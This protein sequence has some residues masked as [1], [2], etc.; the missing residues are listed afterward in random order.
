MFPSVPR[1]VRFARC[2]RRHRLR[3]AQALRPR[4]ARLRHDAAARPRL[5]HRLALTARPGSRLPPGDRSA[6]GHPSAARPILRRKFRS[7]TRRRSRCDRS[8]RPAT[9]LV[10]AHFHIWRMAD[11]P[12]LMGPMQPRIFGPCEPIRR[13][14]SIAEY[15]DDI[16]GKVVSAAIYVQA[17]W[18]RERAEDEVAWV[19]SVAEETGWLRRADRRSGVRVRIAG[20]CRPDNGAR[21][22]RRAL[23]ENPRFSPHPALPCRASARRRQIRS[24]PAQRNDSPGFERGGPYGA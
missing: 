18:P 8:T 9:S 21:R 16:A 10:D 11:L 22:A 14:D 24:S 7:V 12:W 17:D 23:P 5:A 3:W 6:P 1:F 2:T 4:G 19:S 20:L 13:D 15:L